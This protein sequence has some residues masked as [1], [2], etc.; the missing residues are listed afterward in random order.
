MQVQLEIDGARIE[1]GWFGEATSGPEVIV[2]LHEG[3]G[4]LSSWRHFPPKVAETTGLRVFAYSRVGHGQSSTLAGPRGPDAL[5]VEALDALPKVLDKIGFHKGL[6]LGHSDGGS[7]ATIYAGCIHNQGVEGIILIEPHFNVEEKNLNAIRAMADAFR[8]TDLRERL[9]RHHA[10]VDGMFA[11]WKGMWLHPD[12]A[13][14][15]LS[16]ELNKVDVPVLY[17]K[18]EDDPYSTNLQV[19]LAEANCPA[20]VDT[21]VIRGS[22]HFPYR[23]DPKA[24]LEAIAAFSRKVLSTPPRSH[25]G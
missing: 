20:Q 16:A 24:T 2:M 8:S 19:E 22:G 23:N 21:V 25:A 1:G 18:G 3:L 4:S 15:D 17:I 7:I 5:R 12:F 11:A 9:A 13:T 10:D 6:L 14:F